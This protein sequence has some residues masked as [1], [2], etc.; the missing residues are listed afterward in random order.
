MR[1][2]SSSYVRR[3]LLI[4]F[5]FLGGFALLCISGWVMVVRSG[6]QDTTLV[7]VFRWVPV[8]LGALTVLFGFYLLNLPV[9]EDPEDFFLG[10]DADGTV[11]RMDGK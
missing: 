8:I 6:P 3:L 7:T 9:P 5:C 2:Q 10:D 11:E 1:S 4:S